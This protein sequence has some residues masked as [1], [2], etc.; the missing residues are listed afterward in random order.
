MISPNNRRVKHVVFLAG[1][2]A[3]LVVFLIL[4]PAMRASADLHAQPVLQTTPGY[5]PPATQAPGGTA[6]P[7]PQNPTPTGAVTLSGSPMPTATLTLTPTLAPN[8]FKTENSEMN[9]ALVTPALTETQSPS[10][11]PYLSPTLTLTQTTQPTSIPGKTGGSGFPMDWGMFWMGFSFP[12]IA[13]CG[14]VLYF[15]DHRPDFF[16]PR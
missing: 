2:L 9:G 3:L 12:V 16:R 7:A 15:L 11:T 4:V 8:I 14:L 6:Y 5:E 13:G 10:L 1:L